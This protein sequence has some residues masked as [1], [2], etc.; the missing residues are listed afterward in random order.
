[1]TATRLAGRPVAE[2]IW[3]DIDARV[4]ALDGPPCLAT[5]GDGQDPASLSYVGQIRST[6]GRHG[7]DV[8]EITVAGTDV[9][10]A[11]SSL[12]KDPGVHGVL[13]QWPLPAGVSLDAV[14][15]ALPARLDVEGLLP[16]SAGRLALGRP[17]VAPSTAMAGIE[18]L[19]HYGIPMEGQVAVVIG[20]SPIVGR[21]LAQLLLV[22]SATVVVTHSRT[23]DL[24]SLTRQADIL[25]AAAGRAAL[26]RPEMV[27]PGATVLDFGANELD[28]K[29][30]GDVHADVAEVAGA[31]TPVPGGIGAVTVSVLARNLLTLLAPATG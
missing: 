15:G 12:A 21:P 23:R 10:S 22:E 11:V 9:T 14:E 18:M 8:R 17:G 25:L 30:V 5:V 27:K 20:R 7:I 31:L 2:R 26:V 3:A 24:A 16:V 1:M 4:A 19:R 6:L 13:V 28:G 29:F